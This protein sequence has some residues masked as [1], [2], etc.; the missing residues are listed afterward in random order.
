M[1]ERT[2]VKRKFQKKSEGMKRI[3]GNTVGGLTSRMMTSHDLGGGNGKRLICSGISHLCG[4][5]GIGRKQ[6]PPRLH[7]P[8]PRALRGRVAHDGSWQGRIRRLAPIRR[9]PQATLHDSPPDGLHPHR[10]HSI[11]Q[12]LGGGVKQGEP[13]RR[14]WVAS[15]SRRRAEGGPLV[16]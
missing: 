12:H 10:L 2:R 13:A 7:E 11:I 15:G 4:G 14:V 16:T 5:G 9:R 1:H 8:R 6:P 3:A